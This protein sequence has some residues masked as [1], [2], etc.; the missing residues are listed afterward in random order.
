MRKVAHTT[1][2]TVS[3]DTEALQQTR[4]LAQEL[5]TQ[6][7]WTTWKECGR[8]P[9]PDQMCFVAMFPAGDP[10]D[11]FAPRCKTKEDIG[12]GYFLLPN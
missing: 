12:F 11:H 8:C 4:S 5:R 6:L 7:D 3:G 2:G 10:E 1:N 9:E